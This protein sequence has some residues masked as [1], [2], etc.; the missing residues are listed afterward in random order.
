MGRKSHR[1]PHLQ[2][3]QSCLA[4]DPRLDQEIFFFGGTGKDGKPAL[5][6]GQLVT[7]DLMRGADGRL[8]ATNI[9]V[10][11]DPELN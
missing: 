9:E 11:E 8:Y 4:V 10:V 7:Y 2:T 1:A 6:E 5:R 3:Q